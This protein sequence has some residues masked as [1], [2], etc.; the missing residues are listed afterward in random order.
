M[1]STSSVTTYRGEKQNNDTN[2]NCSQPVRLT[3]IDSPL[4][5]DR[6]ERW[7]NEQTAIVE[8]AALVEGM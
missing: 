6:I 8:G 2:P 4:T 7:R 5:I 3:A 1:W